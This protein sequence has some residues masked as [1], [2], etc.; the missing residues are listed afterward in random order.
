MDYSCALFILSRRE[1]SCSRYQLLTSKQSLFVS[2]VCVLISQ[3][4]IPC[5]QLVLLTLF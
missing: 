5:A 2:L 4:V 3:A 1:N